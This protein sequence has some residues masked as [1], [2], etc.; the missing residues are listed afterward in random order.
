M[1]RIILYLPIITLLLLSCKTK[2]ILPSDFDGNQIEFGSGGGFSGAV[3]SYI[4]LENGLLFQKESFTDSIT[5]LQKL[6]KNVTAQAFEN[7]LFL[8]LDKVEIDEPNNMYKFVS[9]KIADSE[10]IMTWSGKSDVN[11]LNLFYNYLKTLRSDDK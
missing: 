10:H 4:L 5:F 9:V 7:Y 1:N 6:D 2:A 11:N 8:Q 3:T